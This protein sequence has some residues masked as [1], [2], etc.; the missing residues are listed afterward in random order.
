MYRVIN[1]HYYKYR[2]D[3][4]VIQSGMLGLCEAANNYDP[5][6]G[7]FSTYACVCIR[8]EIARELK[9][10]DKDKFTISLEDLQ[11]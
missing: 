4:D 9:R 2:K 5:E 3:E 11:W 1:E 8:R 10:R 6:K 7:K